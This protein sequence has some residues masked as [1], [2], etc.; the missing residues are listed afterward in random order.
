MSQPCQITIGIHGN[1]VGV[2]FIGDENS[3]VTLIGAMDCVKAQLIERSRARMG[4]MSW[5]AVDG[6]QNNDA[7]QN[8]NKN[9]YPSEQDVTRDQAIEAT[10]YAIESLQVRVEKM[11]ASPESAMFTIDPLLLSKL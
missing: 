11:R 7:L 1:E 4:S 2:R 5:G 9:E 8:E 3:L 6:V 10:L